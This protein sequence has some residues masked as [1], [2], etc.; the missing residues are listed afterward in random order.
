MGALPAASPD[1]IVL[2]SPHH[3]LRRGTRNA[4]PRAEDSPAMRA[5]MDDDLEGSGYAL[6]LLAHQ[7]VY[8]HW[9]TLRRPWLHQITAADRRSDSRCTTLRQ[10]MDALSEAAAARMRPN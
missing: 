4:H 7:D 2:A 10:D 1:E 6:M 9:E 3:R 8:P 5:L